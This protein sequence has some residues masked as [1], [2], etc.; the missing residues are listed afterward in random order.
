MLKMGASEPWPK[1][2]FA[3]TG[4]YKMKADSLVKYFKPLNDFLERENRGHETGWTDAC[5]KD[6]YSAGVAN[7]AIL[8]VIAACLFATSLF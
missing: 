4:Q 8:S 2:M 5:P 6:Y 3:L 1:A 7:T